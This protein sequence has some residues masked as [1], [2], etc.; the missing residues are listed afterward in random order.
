MP[1]F[2]LRTVDDAAFWTKQVALIVE[3]ESEEDARQVAQLNA[4]DGDHRA[5]TCLSWL[6][7]QASTCRELHLIPESPVTALWHPREKE[8]GTV[9]RQ[10]VQ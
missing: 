10:E 9:V 1:L 3:A 8:A 2:L 6:N 4:V 5:A 7:D